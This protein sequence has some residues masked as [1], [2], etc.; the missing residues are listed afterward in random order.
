MKYAH[1]LAFLS[2]VKTRFLSES[3]W[4]L[5]IAIGALLASLIAG[6]PWIIALA[7]IIGSTLVALASIRVL[8][9]K[10]TTGPT[11]RSYYALEDALRQSEARFRAV[12]NNSPDGILFL[13]AHKNVVYQRSSPRRS[14]HTIEIDLADHLE[15]QQIHPDDQ[16]IVCRTLDQVFQHPETIHT[17]EYRVRY[18][19]HQWQWINVS[20]QNLLNNPDVQAIIVTIRN[21]TEHKH[22]EDRLREREQIYRQSIEIAGAVPYLY[23]YGPSHNENHFEFMGEGIRKITG[24]SPEEITPTHWESIT[25]K[26]YLLGDLAAYS[27]EEATRRVRAGLNS[28]WNC[29]YCIR[30]RDG[31]LH[32][33]YGSS[34]ELHDQHGA[35]YGSIG[36]LQDITEHKHAEETRQKLEAQLVQSQKMEAIGHLAGGIAHDFNNLLVPIIG[37]TDMVLMTLSPDDERHEDLR[38]VRESADRA[39]NLTRQILAF[40]RKQ[41]MQMRSIDLNEL[42]RDFQDMIRRLIG[43]QIE[44]YVMLPPGLALIDADTGQIEQVLLNLV[45]NARDAMPHGGILTIEIDIIN[46]E[47]T[48]MAHGGEHLVPGA[49]VQLKVNDTGHGI[50]PDALPHIFEPFFT[51]KERGKGTGLGLATAYGIIKQH[52]GSITVSS[53]PGNGTTFALYLPQ[54]EQS[55]QAPPPARIE[56]TTTRNVE[57]ILVVEDEEMVRKLVCETLGAHGYTVIEAANPEDGL[58]IAHEYHDAIDLLLTDVI[59]PHMDGHELYQHIMTIRGEL[60]VLYMSGYARDVVGNYKIPIEDIHFLQKPFTVIGLIEKVRQVLRQSKA[61]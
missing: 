49:Y 52:G 39:A 42:V 5:G 13:D 56:Q 17:I 54:T 51:T 24:Y 8:Q 16:D 28:T 59:M 22:A 1:L 53:M 44:L 45:I 58:R 6:T 32:W 12:V 21:I 2:S 43:E 35:S 34:V 27:W 60:S 18:S 33:I 47:A 19:D 41:A 55:I 31:S 7:T 50:H 25:E 57:T 38:H 4:W 11:Q 23:I 40:S 3:C 46:L 30:A 15:R 36:I 61:T 37:Y 48:H 14:H 10:G 9:R 26:R 20:A 29:E